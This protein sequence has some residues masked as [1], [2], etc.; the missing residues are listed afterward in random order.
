MFLP[1]VS[2]HDLFKNVSRDM[3]D[4]CSSVISLA[5][6]CLLT[7]QEPAYSRITRLFLCHHAKI[8]Q[9]HKKMLTFPKC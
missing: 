2:L 4:P 9:I 6:D 7:G 3:F 8:G 1:Q 5:I